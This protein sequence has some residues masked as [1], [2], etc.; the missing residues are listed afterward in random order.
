MFKIYNYIITIAKYKYLIKL[1]CD[2]NIENI[3][4]K[5]NII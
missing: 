1:K 5:Y 3:M 2:N 4:I